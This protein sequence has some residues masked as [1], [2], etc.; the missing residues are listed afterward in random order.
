MFHK[1]LR[2]VALA[3]LLTGAVQ[4]V[5]IDVKII[6]NTGGSTFTPPLVSTHPSSTTLFTSGS[7]SSVSL[8]MMAEGGD[9]SG[10]AADL[11]AVDAVVVENPNG[12]GLIMAGQNTTATL[13]SNT[14]N[15]SLSIVAMILPTNDGFIALNDWKIPTEAGTYT[16]QLNAYDAGTEANDEIINGAGAPDAPG[17]PV[18]P[19]G[20]GGTGATGIASATIEGF[21][22]IHRGILGDMNASGGVS[23]LDSAKHRWLNPVATAII[24]VK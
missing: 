9:T 8:Q 15:D 19:S 10:L 2:T 13:E 7:A 20:N 17:I 24:T 21:V 3:G 22:H 11:T 1:I 12:N 5:D 14:T 18:D 23:D 6:N 16:V 4:A